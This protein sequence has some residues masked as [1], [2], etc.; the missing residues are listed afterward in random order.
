MNPPVN[1]FLLVGGGG[2]EA[3]FALSLARDAT[4]SAFVTHR[5]P[6]ILACV[7]SSGGSF[8]IGDVRDP[9]AITR[10]ALENNVDYAFV[11]ADEP[12]SHGVVDALLS[13]GVKA[14]G[15]TRAA[16]R[17]EWDKIYAMRVM[18]DVAPEFTPLFTVVETP[19][20]I[21]DSLRI[22][23]S[24]KRE[25]VVK[26]QGLTGGKG[27][28]VMPEHL[29]DYRDCENYARELF[30]TR[31]HECVLLV[32]KLHGIEFTVMGLTDGHNLVMSPA[33]Y[34]YPFRFENDTGP[35]TGGMGCFTAAGGKL[36]FLSDSDIDDCE[37][38]MRRVLERLAEQGVRFHGVLNGGFFKTADGIRF[39][40]FNSRFGDPEGLN[41]LTVLQDSFAGVLRAMHSENLSADSVSFIP[42]ASVIKY[43]VA[44]EYPAASPSRSEFTVDLAS[45]RKM[46]LAV[47]FGA[48]EQIDGNRFSTLGSSRVLAIGATAAD[49]ASASDR[50]NRGIDQ[51]V[52][53]DLEYRTDIGS[54]ADIDR[55]MARGAQL[56][57]A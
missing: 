3:S 24:R 27:V 35:G 54:Q 12:L 44:A 53:G 43:L 33:S 51:Y 15:A 19:D 10:F 17:I 46:E 13:A 48:A 32:E 34:D 37:T 49:I 9:D 25:V 56:S 50:I 4:V 5:N 18:Q 42:E 29:R 52:A 7:Q 20:D 45:L 11:S 55:L 16:S 47:F 2:R 30:A 28:K 23:S 22:F 39:M 1:H 38:I 21:P 14:I 8:E 41:I 26:P 31:P 36:P 40:E 57:R 6:T